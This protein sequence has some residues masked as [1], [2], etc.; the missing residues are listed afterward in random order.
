MGLFDLFRRPPAIRDSSGLA[1]F[2]DKNAAFLIQKGMYEYS[3]ARAGHYAKVLMREPEFLEAIERSR[4]RGFPLGLAMVAEMVEKIL[5]PAIVADRRSGIDA[6]AA[7]VLTVFDRYPVPPSL[8][9]S[10]WIEARSDLVRR[11]DQIGLH[12]PKAVKDIPLNFA[13]AYFEMMPI[14]EKLRAPD[15]PAIRNYLRVSLINIHDELERR[16]DVAA[17]V[18]SLLAEGA[19]NTA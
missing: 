2:I 10:A 17:A 11:L 7:L 1:D 16:I 19:D 12:P 18:Q 5:H 9:A 8:G 13:E 6:L 3:R 4:W 14:H 15:F